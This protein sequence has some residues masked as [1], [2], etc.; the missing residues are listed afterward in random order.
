MLSADA[1]VALEVEIIS[2]SEAWWEAFVVPL[3][4]SVLAAATAL[5][6]VYFAGKRLKQQMDDE[7]E[8][9]R[10][11]M[12]AEQKRLREQIE[13]DDR[14]A[15]ERWSAAQRRELY[16]RH[17]AAEDQLSVDL[18]RI[19]L[20]LQRGADGRSDLSRWL[21][22]FADDC[23]DIQRIT[24]EVQIVGSKEYSALAL[25]LKMVTFQFMDTGP[26]AFA[27]EPDDLARLTDE[28]HDA[29]SALHDRLLAVA[30]HDLGVA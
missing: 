4:S 5:V 1:Y 24:D 22:K 3:I 7:R 21:G 15:A 2:E 13:A 11:Q 29:L 16:A 19:T 26:S 9:L 20:A 25:Q 28:T 17:L 12:A 27:T 14:R 8:R 23:Q 10:E 6:V 30:R 18:A